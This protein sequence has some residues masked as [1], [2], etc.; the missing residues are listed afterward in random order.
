[1]P[2]TFS[3]SESAQRGAFTFEK[4]R[5]DPELELDYQKHLAFQQ[6]RAALLFSALA[7]FLWSIFAVIDVFRVGDLPVWDWLVCSRQSVFWLSPGGPINA[8]CFLVS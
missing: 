8:W 1:M 4:L 6:R 3:P 2:D 7:G 5:F